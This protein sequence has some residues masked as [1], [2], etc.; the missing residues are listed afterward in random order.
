MTAFRCAGGC[1]AN[2]QDVQM[3]NGT[4]YWSD[5]KQWPNGTLPKEGDNVYINPG[6]N[7]VFD[8]PVSPLYRYI[9]INGHVTF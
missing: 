1:L 2:V 3:E 4:R 9:E 8:L 7:W 6:T 5:P